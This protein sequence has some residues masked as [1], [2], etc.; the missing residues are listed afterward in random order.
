MSR[1][2]EWDPI[3]IR[4]VH[5][6]LDIAC[7]IAAALEK[8]KQKRECKNSKDCFFRENIFFLILS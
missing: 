6:R 4:L 8:R 1:R 5:G 3:G 7:R 2:R